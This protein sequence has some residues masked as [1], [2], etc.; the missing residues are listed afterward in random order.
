MARWLGDAAAA[1]GDAE[2]VE[3][4]D[5]MAEYGARLRAMYG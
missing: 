4:A 2:I 5:L 3:I 1:L